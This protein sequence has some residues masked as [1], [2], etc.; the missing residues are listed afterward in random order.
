MA[1]PG[2][3]FPFQPCCSLPGAKKNEFML[4]QTAVSQTQEQV[5]PA[6]CLSGAASTPKDPKK[7]RKP[8]IPS[9]VRVP[10]PSPEHLHLQRRA[11]WMKSSGNSAGNIYQTSAEKCNNCS[12]SEPYQLLAYQV[13]GLIVKTAE[14]TLPSS[15]R[16]WVQARGMLA[17]DLSTENNFRIIVAWIKY[18]CPLVPWQ[19]EPVN[20]FKVVINLRLRVYGGECWTTFGISG[21]LVWNIYATNQKRVA[22]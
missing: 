17:S 5:L 8:N 1:L 21:T 16:F 18:P 6:W 22:R 11:H 4:K 9:S 19:R 7:T 10:W 20:L 14:L 13:N 12:F 3:Q 15:A 2:P